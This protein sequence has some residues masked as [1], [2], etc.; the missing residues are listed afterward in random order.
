VLP[1]EAVA[2]VP[3]E[4]RLLEE[5]RP[6]A[7]APLRWE[8]AGFGALVVA[9]IGTG[10]PF[11]ER[12]VSL[13]GGIAD[14]ASL[15]LG[16]AR[17]VHE[18]ERFH[19]LVET[20]EAV[21]WEADPET[22]GFTFL[23]RRADLVFGDPN[24]EERP[25]R[26]WGDHIHREDRE[27]MRI[28]LRA[29]VGDGGDHS[30][31]YRAVGR[32][33]ERMWLRDLVHVSRDARGEV[34]LRGLIVDITERKLAE[35]ALRQ[36]ERKYLEAFTREREAKE[37]L[38]RLDEMKNTFLEAVSHDLRTPLT[39]ILG[40]ALT[41]EHSGSSLPPE[42]SDDLLRRIAANARKLERLLSDLLDLDRLRRGNIE[43]QRRPTD[44]GELVRAIV[45]EA[46]LLGDRVV[47]IDVDPGLTADVDSAKVER[48]LENLLANAARHTPASSRVWVSASRREAGLLLVVEDEGEGVPADLRE[49]IFE[50]FR[51]APGPSEHDPGVG[52]GLALVKNFAKLHRGAAWVEERPG[53]GASFRVWLPDA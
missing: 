30:L 11:G 21:F 18:L 6:V 15:A 42:V 7:V 37:Q 13:L 40:S 23:S 33:G 41:L 48:I 51:Q 53:G 45:N 22:L 34:V 46:E 17:R 28:A 43:P 3:A 29:A 1:T 50:E 36:S 49:E 44:V 32:E 35:Q 38:E 10:D 19:E 24:A 12:D 31:E 47:K 27:R 4:W 2:Q 26:T 39:S 9:A 20:L 52:I 25:L 5:P 14:I 16:S 8:P